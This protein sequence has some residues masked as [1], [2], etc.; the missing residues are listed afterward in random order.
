M[1]INYNLKGNARKELVKAISEITGTQSEYKGAPS[2]AYEIG[3]VTV[4]KNGT[5]EGADKSLKNRLA[6]IGFISEP[7][8]EIGLTIDVPR[9][10]FTVT[11]IDNLQKLIE[12]KANLIKKAV[13]TEKLNFVIS[14]EK[15]SFPWFN[16]DCTPKEVQAYT[17]FIT[18]LC[19]MAKTLQRVNSTGR[20]VGNEKYAFR[21]FL[22]RLGF[23]GPEYKEMRKILL[24]NLVGSSL[25]RR[26]QVMR[27]PS[28]EIV[29][30]IRKDYPKGTRVKLL[31]MDDIQAPPIGTMGTVCGVDDTGSILVC[32]DNGSGL[33]VVYGEDLC[34]K[35]IE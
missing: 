29:E 27:F 34:E 21:C 2:F 14:E 19:D 16:S 5:V 18:A 8:Y 4:D 11:A 15:I 25:L 30:R 28:K 24:K 20:A 22:L 10:D 13:G 6:E 33:N 31:K 9:A 26:A 3:E 17:Y 7:T 35:I 23:I 1:Q 32:W 12:S